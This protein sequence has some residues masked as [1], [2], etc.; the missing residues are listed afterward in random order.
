VVRT[1]KTPQLTERSEEHHK[2]APFAQKYGDV[3]TVPSQL[4]PKQESKKDQS[5]NQNP[6]QKRNTFLRFTSLVEGPF[7]VT[8]DEE[9]TPTKEGGGSDAEEL[10]PEGLSGLVGSQEEVSERLPGSPEISRDILNE[11]EA[12]ATAIQEQKA[13]KADDATVPKLYG[14]NTCSRTTQNGG[15]TKGGSGWL[16]RFCATECSRTGRLWRG[17]RSLI[18]LTIVIHM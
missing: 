13:V 9:D 14:K 5:R 18:G 4:Y 12:A 11:L 2:V 16:A 7:S 3:K 15:S 10:F 17:G 6:K 8:G 1:K